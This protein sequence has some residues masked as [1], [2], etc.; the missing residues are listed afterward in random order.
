VTSAVSQAADT[1]LFHTQDNEEPDGWLHIN[2]RDFDTMLEQTMGVS[3]SQVRSNVN[4]MDV[5]KLEGEERSED[6]IATEHASK[7]Q[8]LAAKVEEFVEGEG[9]L[10]GA[11]FEE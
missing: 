3:E 11:R 4:A 7:L 2:A 6:H 9:D 10:E 1:P 5:D 8:D